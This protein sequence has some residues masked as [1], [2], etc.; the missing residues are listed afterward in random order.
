MDIIRFLDF[1]HCPVLWKLEKTF[2][3]VDQFPSSGGGE[4]KGPSD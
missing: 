2:W 1:V 4:D 3:K